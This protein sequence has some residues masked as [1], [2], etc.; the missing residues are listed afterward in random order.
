VDRSDSGYGPLEGS[1]EHG[2]EPWGF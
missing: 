2:N 1:C